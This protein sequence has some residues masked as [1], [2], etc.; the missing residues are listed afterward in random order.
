MNINSI[1]KKID[2]DKRLNIEEIVFL[3]KL[4]Q[5]DVL[6]LYHKADS[7]RQKFMGDEIFVRGI[8]EFSNYC[9]KDCF[10]CGI[11]RS[12]SSLERYRI[13]G[14]EILDACR[15]LESAGQTTVVLQS[16]EDIQ[17][18]KEIIG[19]LILK[20]KRE[21]SL[22]ITLSVGERDE[23]TYAY[24]RNKGVDRYLLR[25]ETSD[26]ELFK[27]CHPDDDFATRINCLKNIKN[28][29]IQTGSGFMIGLPE[30]TYEQLACDIQFCTDLDLDMIGIGP[31]IPHEK[32]KFAGTSN[33][34]DKEVYFKVISIIRLLNKKAHIP[35]TTAFDTIDSNG[36]NLLLQRGANIFMPND[37]PGKYRDKYL[38]YPGKPCVDELP[39]DCAGCVKGRVASLGRKMGEGPGHSIK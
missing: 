14:E 33:P 28:A 3:L 24:W 16:G 11:G 20:I 7:V 5:D 38:L 25:F 26:R 6:N 31:F 2:L 12:N 10:Y 30:E 21:T 36:R 8:I 37:T 32:T 29:G 15:A 34:F 4:E 35:A 18:T 9:R 1:F 23:E 22:A 13:S 17:Y 19:D 39:S 27:K